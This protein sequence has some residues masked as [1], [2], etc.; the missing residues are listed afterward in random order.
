M[1]KYLIGADLG[2]QGT[3]T[4]LFDTEMNPAAQSF[5][6][7][8]LISPCP[9]TTWEEPEDMFGSVISGVRQ[10]ME[11][12][13]VSPKDVLALGIDSQMAGILGVDE[14][15]QASTVYDSWLDTR[16]APQALNMRR[17]AGK[18]ITEITGG[19]VTCTHGPKILWWKENRPE[20]Y[21][22]TCKFVPPHGYVTGRLCGRKGPEFTFDYTC[23]QYSG[24]G[25]NQ[26]KRW[27]PELLELFGVEPSKM[28]RIVPPFEILGGITEDYAAAM[29]LCPGT[30]VA[31]GAGDTAC[32]I[33][34]SGLFG[35][36]E[37]LDCAGTASVL[38]CAV[39]SFVP[40]TAFDT[41]TMMR[42]PLDGV[43]YPLA[44]INGGGMD[45][46]WL[47]REFTGEPP[48]PYRELE[49][50]ASSL[51]CGSEGLLFLPHF[52][53]RV[54]PSDPSMKGAF[55]GLDWRHTRSHLFRAVMEGISYEYAY[56]LQVLR[57][58]YPNTDFRH[59]TAV[60]GGAKSSLFLSLKADI[61]GVDVSPLQTG[62]TAPVGSAVIAGVGAGVFADCRAPIEKTLRRRENFACHRERHQA[63]A[64]YREAY[65][66]ALEALSPLYRR[67]PWNAG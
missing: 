63:Y 54:L 52:S 51:P 7:S 67:P 29:G 14:E 62:D 9:G 46:A 17:R 31:A 23:L 27:S 16:C 66:Q 21:R 65:L 2:T 42:S 43:W 28:A 39:D 64:S 55:L 61:L 1:V 10:V 20:A 40:D 24:F 33:F 35:N 26:G 18:R 56:Y 5:L 44:Y 49:E 47:R 13:G 45:V 12:S 30:P 6:P 37:L 25:D 19:P 11:R 36:G 59:M 38:C 32:S 53:G 50:A 41:M 34:G 3:K 57:S 22:R 48:V 8:K 4:V 60:G 58:L 15:G